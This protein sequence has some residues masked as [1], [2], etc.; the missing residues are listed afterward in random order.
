MSCTTSA[1]WCQSRHVT[2]PVGRGGLPRWRELRKRATH[3]QLEV[4][5]SI[6]AHHWSPNHRGK[7]SGREVVP[8][9]PSLD[10]LCSGNSGR[11][12]QWW[13]R[14]ATLAEECIAQATPS[15]C[16]PS[17]AIHG[18][19]STL[20]PT[21]GPPA[22]CIVLETPYALFL[23]ARMHICRRRKGS[24][25]QWPHRRQH[26][27]RH[28]TQS[29]HRHHAPRSHCRRPP[30]SDAP[31][32]ASSLPVSRCTLQPSCSTGWERTPRLS[33]GDPPSPRLLL[34]DSET[35]C[36][37]LPSLCSV[38]RENLS[39]CSQNP[40]LDESAG[41]QTS[42]R[43]QE[44][45]SLETG[46]CGLLLA[47][48][49]SVD[50]VTATPGTQPWYHNELRCAAL[51]VGAVGAAPSARSLNHSLQCSACELLRIRRGGSGSFPDRADRDAPAKASTRSGPQGCG[52]VVTKLKPRA[53]RGVSACR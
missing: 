8:G 9:E 3:L 16:K 24:Q 46:A 19:R 6:C 43:S 10:V 49:P 27:P 32:P 1:P 37:P 4:S 14:Q 50:S 26:Q 22:L 15:S 35:T 2:R 40:R 52:A 30:H 20:A 31:S 29:R 41:A 33:Y 38:S 53:S 36:P 47:A 17:R 45:G 23:S 11:H 48:S 5:H 51:R 44:T 21:G 28:P 25:Q 13:G 34:Q 18:P 39:Q 7:H 42:Q 12:T